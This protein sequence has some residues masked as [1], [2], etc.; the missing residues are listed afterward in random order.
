MR[1]LVVFLILLFFIPI[2]IFGQSLSELD[3]QL[4]E[5]N[6]QKVQEMQEGKQSSSFSTV[7]CPIGQIEKAVS[8]GGIICVNDSNIQSPISLD[9]NTGYIVI[10]VIVVIIIIAA[11]AR[12]KGTILIGERRGF[13]SSVK[14]Q[15]LRQQDHRCN[16]CNRVLDVVDYDHI[17]G[18]RSNNEIS[19]CQALCPNCHAKKSRRAQ[20]GE[21]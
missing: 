18:N 17:D 11:L 6:K 3:K 4:D 9:E 13:S 15:V 21:N 16:E 14:H 10:G 7:D 12:S 20:M 8:G 1:Y 5:Q 2:Q 19:N